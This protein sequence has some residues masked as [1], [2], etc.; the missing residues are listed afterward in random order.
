MLDE[1]ERVKAEIERFK[2]LFEEEMQF[3]ESLRFEYAQKVGGNQGQDEEKTT[4]KEAS[5]PARTLS[6]PSARPTFVDC[7]FRYRKPELSKNSERAI[8]VP[9]PFQHLA[10]KNTRSLSCF[11][12]KTDG[13]FANIGMEKLFVSDNVPLTAREEVKQR[14]EAMKKTLDLKFENTSGKGSLI[15]AKDEEP[16]KAKEPK[17]SGSKKEDKQ[18]KKQAKEEKKLEKKKEKERKKLEKELQKEAKKKA[19]KNPAVPVSVFNSTLDGVMSLQTNKPECDIPIILPTLTKALTELNG[20]LT[21][22]NTAKATLDSH[23]ISFLVCTIT[24][25]QTEGIF[26]IPAQLE[27]VME[28]KEQLNNQDYNILSTNPH[29][30]GACLKL[31]FR[32]L[33]EPLIPNEL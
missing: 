11:D 14:M 32:E 9:E 30:V 24:G 29:A 2:A 5:L 3:C 19:N 22:C 28:L 16:A 27:E 15:L 4:E 8:S 26:R 17:R 7:R 20:L 23:D 13:E 25:L 31:W 10:T 21:S 12:E 1:I 6:A 33:S 18:K